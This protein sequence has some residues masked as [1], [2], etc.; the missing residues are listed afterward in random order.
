[1]AGSDAAVHCFCHHQHFPL[2]EEEGLRRIGREH[3]SA[4]IEARRPRRCR[5]S[6]KLTAWNC[7]SGITTTT[8][9]AAIADIATADTGHVSVVE[10]QGTAAV[11]VSPTL[12]FSPLS[13]SLSSLACLVVTALQ[14]CSSSLPREKESSRGPA[15]AAAAADTNC[16]SCRSQSVSPHQPVLPVRGAYH[17]ASAHIFFQLAATAAAAASV[18][19]A[20]STTTTINTVLDSH[21]AVSTRQQHWSQFSEPSSHI[22]LL[23]D[24]RYHFP[25]SFLLHCHCHLV[26]HLLLVSSTPVSSLFSSSSPTAFP[27]PPL[28]KFVLFCFASLFFLSFISSSSS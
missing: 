20:T 11:S 6:A 14:P 17:F 22:L 25:P 16:Q 23:P 8:T 9:T 15:T 28:K 7:C 12:P 3:V 18:F 5:H 21:C 10:E 27:L 4:Q 2:V 26:Q 19:S 1:M 24:H 13:T